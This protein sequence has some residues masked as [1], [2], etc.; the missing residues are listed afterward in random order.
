MRSRYSAF[1][2]GDTAY[3]LR[4]WHPDTRPARLDLD[5]DRRWTGLA[6]LETTGGTAFHTSGTV[7]FRAGYRAPEGAGA[8]EETGEFLRLDGTWVYR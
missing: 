3:L 1:A 2:L 8:Q 7:T 5:G 6:I 4:T